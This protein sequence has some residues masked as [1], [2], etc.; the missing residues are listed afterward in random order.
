MVSGLIVAARLCLPPLLFSVFRRR[1]SRSPPSVAFRTVTDQPCTSSR[2]SLFA[3]YS[4]LISSAC[5]VRVLRSS[6]LLQASPPR[7]RPFPLSPPPSPSPLASLSLSLSFTHTHTHTHSLMAGFI[8]FR[9]SVVTIAGHLVASHRRLDSA[10]ALALF[11][12]AS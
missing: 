3:L 11:V 2:G 12:T 7:Y 1:L 9:V 10:L 8:G 5:R 6:G 4:S